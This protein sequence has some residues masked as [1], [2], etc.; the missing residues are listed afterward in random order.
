MCG[1]IFPE[2]E[3]RLLLRRLSAE[4]K[5]NNQPSAPSLIGEN[6][7]LHY[8][9]L[10]LRLAVSVYEET[11]RQEANKIWALPRSMGL[12]ACVH[13]R[14]LET[15]QTD[16][17][18]GDGWGWSSWSE[19]PEQIPGW[20]SVAPSR[21]PIVIG[22]QVPPSHHLSRCAISVPYIRKLPESSIWK[23]A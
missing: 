11:L 2:A 20:S 3:S 5:R 10:C 14:W 23:G 4:G 1:S 8:S 18:G 16:Q 19:A 21:C 13:R 12:L 17:R 7:L 15:T 6:V 22:A 9:P